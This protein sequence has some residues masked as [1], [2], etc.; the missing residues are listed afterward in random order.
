MVLDQAIV[1]SVVTGALGL[2]GLCI[3]KIKFFIRCLPDDESMNPSCGCGFTDSRLLPN[4]S[5]LE[6]HEIRENDLLVIKKG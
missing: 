3:N 1:G 6:T 4:D 2:F 5:R